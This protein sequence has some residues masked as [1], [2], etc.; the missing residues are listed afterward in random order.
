MLV[1][2][3]LNGFKI[4]GET[5]FAKSLTF[6]DSILRGIGQV[7]LQNSS[8]A[9]L[10]FLCGIFHNSTL[11][12]CAALLGTIVST[13][14]A[15][16]LRAEVSQIKNGLYGFNGALTAIGLMF[17]L[18][19]NA[20][21]LS[22]IVLAAAAATVLMAAAMRLFESLKVPVLTAPFVFTTLCFLMACS[23]FGLIQTTQLLPSAGLPKSANVE[24]I[25][26]VTTLTEGLLNGIS[27]VFFQENITT[28]FL[29]LIGLLIS[30]RRCF[31]MALV[32]SAL[33]IITAW[34]LG[35]SEPAMRSGAFGFNAVL[36]AVALGGHFL[37]PS[38]NSLVLTVLGAVIT[39]VA[40]AA[41][42]GAFEPVGMPAMTL[43]FVLVT[44]VFVLAVKNGNAN[45]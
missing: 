8:W 24:G 9:G 2:F 1:T 38:L 43:P 7:M 39:T 21:T 19:P 26:S 40:F 42:S 36:T 4:E 3:N 34:F 31:I 29:F 13:A 12:G 45:L 16:V 32:G 30:S 33:G 22:Y 11:F 25:V 18:Q 10:L 44:W 5:F 15:Y 23:R 14:T 17:F 35:A 41:I 6:L 27:Q 20:I 37:K 28:G